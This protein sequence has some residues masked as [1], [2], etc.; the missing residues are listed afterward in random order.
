MQTTG[1]PLSVGT[2]FKWSTLL[3]VLLI[4]GGMIFVLDSRGLQYGYSR[5]GF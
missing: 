4:G 2:A 5:H 3:E 1:N